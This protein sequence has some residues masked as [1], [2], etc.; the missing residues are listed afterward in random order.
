MPASFL[1]DLD[2]LVTDPNLKGPERDAAIAMLFGRGLRDGI[3]QYVKVTGRGRAGGE[4]P[5]ASGTG[6]EPALPSGARPASASLLANRAWP[7]LKEPAPDISQKFDTSDVQPIEPAAR[8]VT[9]GAEKPKPAASESTTGAAK[10]EG[11]AQPRPAES[12]APRQRPDNRSCDRAQRR[13]YQ[14]RDD[15]RSERACPGDGIRPDVHELEEAWREPPQGAR[16][17]PH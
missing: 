7:A 4:P 2:K 12:S 5:A 1:H 8:K 10:P 6:H 9:P 17:G 16:R 3:V 15:A 13:D 11:A 14:T